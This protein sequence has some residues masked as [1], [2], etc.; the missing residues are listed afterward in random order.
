MKESVFINDKIIKKILNSE[1]KEC[2]EYLARIISGV[3]KIDINTIKD[4]IELIEP[5]VS[6]NINSVDSKVDSIYKTKDNYINIEINYNNK[7]I[8]TIKN[9]IYLYNMILRQVGKSKEYKDV[10]PVIQ[11]NINNYDLFKDLLVG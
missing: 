4:S 10:L 5:D 6:N 3:L 1:K 11:I 8:V 2:R 7:R 9:N